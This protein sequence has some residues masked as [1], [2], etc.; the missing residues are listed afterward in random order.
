[1]M[2][3]N[4]LNAFSV[5][6]EGKCEELFIT[7]L[8]D[9]VYK[10][11][12]LRKC[13]R[14][15][16]C[17]S[18]SIRNPE[19]NNEH[20]GCCQKFIVIDKDNLEDK[21]IDDCLLKCKQWEIDFIITIPCFELVLLSFFVEVSSLKTK[22]WIDDEFYKIFKS[23][24]KHYDKGKKVEN[25][26]T[27]IGIIKSK[28]KHDDKLIDQWEKRLVCLKKNNISQFIDIVDLLK[29]YPSKK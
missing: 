9:T 14:H 23:Y 4:N 24:D 2:K 13:K 5:E 27:I 7:F 21:K 22:R 25:T 28:M 12:I 3:K 17:I 16:K 29:N 8:K 19:I 20:K 15:S 18:G 1:M 11:N 6:C 10:N 26:K